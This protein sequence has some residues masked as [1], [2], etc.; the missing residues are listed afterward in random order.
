LNPVGRTVILYLERIP[1]MFLPAGTRQPDYLKSYCAK[2]AKLRIAQ[3][4]GIGHWPSPRFTL[5]TSYCVTSTV[6][7]E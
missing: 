4:T 6:S 7:A 3:I 5:F 1:Q 2:D